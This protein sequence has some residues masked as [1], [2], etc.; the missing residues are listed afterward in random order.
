M[1]IAIIKSGGKQYIVKVGDKV[2]LEKIK[3]DSGKKVTFDTLLLAEEKGKKVEIGK[4]SLGKKVEGKVL[5]SGREKKVKVVKYKPKT[6]YKVT[7][8]HRQAFTQVQITKI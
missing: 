2:K 6:R 8:G 7:A 4:P 5:Q 3:A 1:S